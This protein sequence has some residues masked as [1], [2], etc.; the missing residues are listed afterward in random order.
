[1]VEPSGSNNIIKLKELIKEKGINTT[2]FL[3]RI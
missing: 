2:P 1:M 3:P